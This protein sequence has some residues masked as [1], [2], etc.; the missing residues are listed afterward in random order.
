MHSRVEARN[1][2]P[3]QLPSYAPEGSTAAHLVEPVLAA[4]QAAV[5]DCSVIAATTAAGWIYTRK[6]EETVDLFGRPRNQHYSSQHDDI[7][8]SIAVRVNAY[9]A[10]PV[11]DAVRVVEALTNEQ[12]LREAHARLE[13]AKAATAAAQYEEARIQAEIDRLTPKEE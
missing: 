7:Y 11:T 3:D 6:D 12:L 4:I 2:Y 1:L 8:L 9:A 5:A 13:T 10:K